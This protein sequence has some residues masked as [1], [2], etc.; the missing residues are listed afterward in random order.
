MLTFD[1]IRDIC[2]SRCDLFRSFAHISVLFR[3]LVDEFLAIES[4]KINHD[5]SFIKNK[6]QVQADEGPYLSKYHVSG[7][8]LTMS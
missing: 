8:R 3:G 7:I 1:K 6:G 2:I 5:Y 4:V